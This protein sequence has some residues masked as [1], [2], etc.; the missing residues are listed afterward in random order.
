M[1]T[2]SRN[3]GFP[4]KMTC[5]TQSGVRGLA[6]RCQFSYMCP[7]DGPEGRLRSSM[8]VCNKGGR[9]FGELPDCSHDNLVKYI[10]S[11][12]KTEDK[13][14]ITRPVL[15]RVCQ[16]QRV[17]ERFSKSTDCRNIK[18]NPTISKL[19]AWSSVEFRNLCETCYRSFCSGSVRLL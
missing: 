16:A 19:Q 1:M 3:W 18:F 10:N 12:R 5:R 11:A 6:I 2:S 15:R 13:R 7:M 4:N 8:V 9:W 17:C 14:V